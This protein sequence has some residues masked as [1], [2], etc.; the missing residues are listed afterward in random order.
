MTNGPI[1]KQS[2]KEWMEAAE[3]YLN[4]PKKDEKK[5]KKKKPEGSAF[6][7]YRGVEGVLEDAQKGKKK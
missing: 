5:K 1:K 4:P 3:K 2:L 6:R 7:D